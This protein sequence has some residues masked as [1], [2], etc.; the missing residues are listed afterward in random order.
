MKC[1]GGQVYTN[2]MPLKTLKCGDAGQE[3]QVRPLLFDYCQEGCECPPGSVL[4]DGQCIS[5]KNCPCYWG[6]QTYLPGDERK[7]DCNTWLV[8][9]LFL[10]FVKT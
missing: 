10:T 7:S 9:F 6:K 5:P 3:I 2:C 8:E 4:Y 1:G